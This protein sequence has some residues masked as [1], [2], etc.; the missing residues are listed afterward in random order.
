MHNSIYVYYLNYLFIA[1]YLTM[2]T[3][4][5]HVKAY[6][7]HMLMHTIYLKLRKYLF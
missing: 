6:S 7:V 5:F 2:I 4:I 3:N 1:I